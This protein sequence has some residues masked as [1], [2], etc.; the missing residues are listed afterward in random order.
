MLTLIALFGLKGFL[1]VNLGAITYTERV[2]KLQSGTVVE[3]FGAYVMQAD[4]VTLW[5]ADQIHNVLK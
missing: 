1:Y 5:V 2:G 4:P 3:Q